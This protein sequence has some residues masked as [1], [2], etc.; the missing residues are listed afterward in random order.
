M[1]K[2]FQHFFEPQQ[3]F[4]FFP[5]EKKEK[6]NHHAFSFIQSPSNSLLQDIK[7][8]LS[9]PHFIPTL[10]NLSCALR[11]FN[12]RVHLRQPWSLL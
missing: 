12:L 1:E 2:S 9:F 10:F 7:V 8:F 4:A 11:S 3:F 6:K 5:K